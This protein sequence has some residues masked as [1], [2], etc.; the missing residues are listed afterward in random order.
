M[1]QRERKELFSSASAQT[2]GLC[3]TADGVIWTKH[4]QDTATGHYDEGS[5]NKALRHTE[6]IFTSNVTLAAVF[7]MQEPHPYVLHHE[8]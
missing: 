4:V 5:T 6:G 2:H 3:S 7:E 8:R 1:E